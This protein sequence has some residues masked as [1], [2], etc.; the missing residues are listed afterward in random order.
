MIILK[1]QHNALLILGY[2]NFDKLETCALVVG[3]E[4]SKQRK[5]ADDYTI[6]NCCC[7]VI[8]MARISFTGDLIF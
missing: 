6:L 3:G 2:I 1:R 7:S 8:L 5:N 4:E